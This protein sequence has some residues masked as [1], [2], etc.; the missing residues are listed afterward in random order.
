MAMANLA[1]VTVSMAAETMGALTL[2]SRVSWEEMSTSRGRT[3][4]N[5]GTRST[6]SKVSASPRNLLFGCAN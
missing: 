4:E 2:I 5:A 3:S 1:S 6:S